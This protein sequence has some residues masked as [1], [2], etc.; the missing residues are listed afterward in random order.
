L[1]LARIWLTQRRVPEVLDLLDK[2]M[3][4]FETGGHL[5]HLTEVF[6]LRSLAYAARGQET[7]AKESF[8]KALEL[9]KPEGYVHV[10]I[11]NGPELIPLLHQV[12]HRFPDYVNQLLN[13]FSAGAN[14]VLPL[15]DS[16][17]EREREIVDL[18][19]L[20]YTNRQIADQLFISVGTVKGHI[21]HIFSKLNVSNRTQAL[22][23]ARELNLITK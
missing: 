5:R 11:E 10:F 20:G 21:N 12:R 6:V 1:L 3:P 22:L 9:G 16:L 13:T 2:V 14:P 23:R 15:L 4:A 19:A 7:M 17:T 8:I 18:I